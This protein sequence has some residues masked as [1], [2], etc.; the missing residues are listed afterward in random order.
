MSISEATYGT[1]LTGVAVLKA[2]TKKVKTNRLL[3]KFAN[4]GLQAFSLIRILEGR[5]VC[6][7]IVMTYSDGKSC[8]CRP[9]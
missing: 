7:A 4:F 5:D 3:N 6:D 1:A 2:A 9:L 8:F